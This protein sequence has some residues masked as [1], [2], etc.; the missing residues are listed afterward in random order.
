MN[1]TFASI[2]CAGAMIAAVVLITLRLR[3]YL[4]VYW[5]PAIQP[6]D[7]FPELSLSRYEPMARLLGRQDLEFLKSQPGYRPEI[8][9]KLQRTRLRVFRSYLVDLA[10]EFQSLHALARRMVANGSAQ[11][12][13]LV[14]LLFRQQVTFWR[15]IVAIELRLMTGSLG[16]GE[17]LSSANVRV[18]IDAMN[19]LRA[20]I[21]RIAPAPAAA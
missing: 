9:R 18:L 2:A 6:A 21:A 16:F 1:W 13:P 17:A 11:D 7:E 12:A 15:A 8:A 14:S 20:E 3:V 19:T 4:R 5:T 10:A